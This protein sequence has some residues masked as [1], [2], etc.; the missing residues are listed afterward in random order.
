MGRNRF[1]S[2]LYENMS[3]IRKGLPQKTYVFAAV[4]ANAY[5]HGDIQAAKTLLKAGVHGFVVALLDE[6]LILRKS[7]IKAPILVLGAT[8]P[9]DAGL[10]ARI[11]Y[12][13]DC[14]P[15]RVAS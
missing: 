6:A 3:G 2:T 15:N 1:R 10:A 12:I 5:G 9:A 13:L 8:R 11:Q 7:G 14:F 4:K